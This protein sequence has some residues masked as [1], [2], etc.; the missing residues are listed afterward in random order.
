MATVADMG[1]ARRRE[2]RAGSIYQR[3]SDGLWV[4]TMEAGWTTTGTRRRVT[5]SAKTKGECQR[6]LRDKRALLDSHGDT[7]VG[8]RTTVK[9]WSEEWLQQV[10]RIQRP[11]AFSNSKSA[12][13]RWIIPTIGARRLA[14]LTPADIRSVAKAQRD[15]G[16]TTSTELRTHSVLM[17]MLKAAS[18]EGHAVP[19]RLFQMKAPK[20]AVSDRDAM[21]VEEA[22][23]VLPWAGSLP[24]GSRFLVA[25]M[26][27]VR[28]AEALGLTWDRIDFAEHAMRIDQQLKPIPYNEPFRPASGFR[29]PDGY[30]ATHLHG[31]LHLVPVKSKAGQRVIPM[32]P[33]V[34]QALLAWRE[35]SR[36][37]I[38]DNPHGLVWPDLDGTP[39]RDPIDNEEWYAIQGAADVGHP[40][41]RYYTIHETRHTTATLLLECGVDPEVV[42]AIMGHSSILTTRGYRHV[43]TARAA[44][45]LN[46]VAQ[47]LRLG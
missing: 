20:K 21:T 45:A 47:R 26:Q 16:R 29:M 11:S 17:T 42:I 19:A 9:D 10:V 12:A 33:V 46:L 37:L 43:R 40:A 3:K 23:A 15:A 44:E 24:H 18:V 1:N 27:G 5:V 39:T 13:N 36:E 8:T 28:Q 14:D 22:L 4:G 32:V 35:V 30:D 7:G 38:P 34:E 31:A 2:Y 41:G 25:L 6:R